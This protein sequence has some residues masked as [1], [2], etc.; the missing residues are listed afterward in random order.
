MFLGFLRLVR[1]AGP[2]GVAK[3]G[4]VQL[5]AAAAHPGVV[6]AAARRARERGRRGRRGG[7][8]ALRGG[9]PS[10]AA[11]VGSPTGQRSGAVVSLG[12]VSEA[13]ALQGLELVVPGQGPRHLRG[14][15]RPPADG[16]LRPDLDLRRGAPTPIP[17][18]GKVLTGL[19]AFWFEHTGEIVPQP[20]RLLHRRARGGAR[21]RRCW[22]SGSRW[23]PW[24]AWCAATSRAR[25][26]RTTRPPARSAASS[27]PRAC[28]SRSSCPSRSSRPPPRPRWAI[29]TRTWTSTGPPRSWATARCSR[30]CA[31]SRSAIYEFGAA[32]ARERGIILADTKFEF[33]RRARRHDRAGRRGAHARL[34]A[35][36]ARRR[37]RARPRAAEL[38]Q[39]VR[40]RLGR[41]LGLGQVAAG[42]RRSPTRSWRAPARAT[43]R[44][45]SGSPASRSGLA[46]AAG[47]V[48]ARV[49]IRPKEGILDPQGQAVERALPALGFEGVSN[50]RVGRLV[51]LEVEDPLAGAGDVRAAA[52][53][54]ADRG[55]RGAGARRWRLRV[56]FGVVRF[57]GCCDEVD[58]LQ[59]CRR[60]ADAELLWHGDRDLDGRGRGG[61]SRRLLLRRLPARGRHRALLAGRWRRSPSSRAPA[62]RCSAS[63]TASRCCARRACC[64]GA[65]LPNDGAALR[66][67]PGRRGGGER[68]H[69]LHARVRGRASRSRSPS[70]T[71][72]AATTRRTRPWTSS[73]PHGQVILRYAAG[74]QPQ[75]LAA[76]HRRRVPTA[77]K[78]VMGLM[79]H[80]EHA[81]DPLTGSADGAKLFA[82][83]VAH[84]D[85]LVATA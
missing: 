18:K 27:C 85:E 11:S 37:L 3:I 76:R 10:A 65:L 53:Q 64:P 66:L 5:V 6:G 79:P 83:L 73:R 70:S 31:G 17:D 21:P 22:S 30:S 16:G 55:L 81:V 26:G 57:P 2:G 49:L 61:H 12:A 56:R 58:A 69:A 51:E 67:P 77:Q 71:P 7:D 29:T 38:R 68:R 32:H 45:T 50:V 13:A 41:G 74:P 82:S 47:G 59:A 48:T 34:L 24:S 72:P 40:A 44:P 84:V 33:G 42:A 35:L 63:A 14:R 46:R 75:R 43:W 78:N 15:R 60:F 80:P 1:G 36:L 25:A 23:C 39:A 52:R 20:P 9:S 19:T 28:R 54:P 62:G 4:Q 8:R